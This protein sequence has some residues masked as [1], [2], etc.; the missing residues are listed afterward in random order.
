MSRKLITTVLVLFAAIRLAAPSAEA[1]SSDSSTE[2]QLESATV[3]EILVEHVGPETVSDALVKANIRVK[4]GDRY[5]PLS[6]NEDIRNLYV[7]GYFDTVRVNEDII[8]PN[9]VNLIYYVQGKPLLTDITFTGNRKFNDKRLLK[10]IESETD[11]PMDDAQ[12]TDDASAIEDKY[13]QAG[14]HDVNVEIERS[15]SEVTGRGSVNFAITEGQRIKIVDVV[16]EGSSFPDKTLRKVLRTRRKGPFS[17]LTGSGKLRRDRFEDDKDALRDFFRER[18]YLDFEIREVRYDYVGED[19]MVLRFDL[20]E[21]KKYLVGSVDFDGNTVYTDEELSEALPMTSGEVFRPSGRFDNNSAVRELYDKEGY[22][23]AN[24][25]VDDSPNIED[26]AIDLNYTIREGNR[27]FIERIEIR[28]NTMTKDHVI[29]REL[30][31]SPGEK[32]NMFLVDRSRLRI[33]RLNLFESV[34]VDTL[35][36]DIENRKDLRISVTETTTGKFRLGAGFSTVDNIVG[37]VEYIES[38]FDIGQWARPWFTGGGQKLRVRAQVG[39]RR[40]DYV[41]N[42][43]EPWFLGR[44]LIFDTELFRQELDFNSDEYDE[45]RTGGR[46]SLTKQ[47]FDERW[48]GTLSYGL[49]EVELDFEGA[50]GGVS[51]ARAEELAAKEASGVALTEQEQADVSAARRALSTDLREAES[52]SRLVSRVGAGLAFDNRRGDPLFPDYGTLTRIDGEVA[53][54]PFGFDTD[55]YRLELRSNWHY[56]SF[57]ESY[58]RTMARLFPNKAGRYET[59]EFFE[60]H[61]FAIRFRTGVVDAFGDSERVPLFDRFFL[62]GQYTLRGYDFREI[63]PRDNAFNNEPLGG[64]SF[65]FGSAEYTIPIVDQ[66]RIAAFYDAGNVYTDTN[67]FEDFGSYSDNW[68]FGIRIRTPLGPLRLDYALPLTDDDGLN[69]TSGRF[70]FS[71][72]TVEN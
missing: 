62:G 71:V 17:W 41:L 26:G 63:G 43:I 12:L 57:V 30:A 32:F 54:G 9:Q 46:L 47:L 4:P 69:R 64:N 11:R 13:E 22:V 36:T 52:G 61:T 27:K 15:V 3:N 35:P 60:G 55:Y 66:F 42:F 20:Y 50:T 72:S 16:F 51:R 21:G 58:Q 7:T 19:R 28:G 67:P 25:A 68:G 31:V 18:G 56:P 10:E 70:Q 14:F 38:N 2:L 48:R 65:W 59:P 53:G 37:F 44:R 49:E 34:S 8:G 40:Q 33:E 23:D 29:R 5:N 1:Q 6:I 39:T 24:Y 45:K